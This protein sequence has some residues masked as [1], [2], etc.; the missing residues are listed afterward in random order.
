MKEET[1]FINE[2]VKNNLEVLV[3][4]NLDKIIKY[5]VQKGYRVTKPPKQVKDEYTFENAWNLYQ[6]KVGC[7]DKLEKKWNSMSF[8]D[9]KAA[10]EHIPLYVM[11]TEDKKYRKNFQTYL[12]QRAWEDEI[13]GSIPP[14]AIANEET[15]STAQLIQRTKASIEKSQNGQDFEKERK[16]LLGMIE[17]VKNNPNSAARR[18]LEFYHISGHLEKYGI[19][20]KL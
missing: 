8:K 2:L 6:K 19:K 17:V 12:N 14:P 9:R 16:R 3:N 20:W 18:S 10:T 7:K 5:L 4:G 13:I 15:S 11:A 1:S